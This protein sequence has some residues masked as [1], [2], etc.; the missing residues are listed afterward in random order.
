MFVFLV[1]SGAFQ[2]VSWLRSV[3]RQDEELRESRQVRSTQAEGEKVKEGS[4]KGPPVVSGPPQAD[5]CYIQLI[6]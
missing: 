2:A 1:S 6:L 5:L 3:G 4:L